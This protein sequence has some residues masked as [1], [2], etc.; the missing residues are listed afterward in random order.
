[1][2]KHVYYY[3]TILKSI[4]ITVFQND[5]FPLRPSVCS[6]MLLKTLFRLPREEGEESRGPTA[7]QRL[8]ILFLGCEMN[9]QEDFRASSKGKVS[10]KW[11]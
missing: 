11:H 4:L 1:M 5:W 7:Q 3:T 2:A 6:F 9:P 8:R 10:K